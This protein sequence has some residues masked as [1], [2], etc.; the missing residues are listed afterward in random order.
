[1]FG[2]RESVKVAERTPLDYGLAM[3]PGNQQ[4]ESLFQ[5]GV[6]ALRQGRAR[7]A[8]LRF[9]QLTAAGSANGLTWLVLAMAR[10]AEGDAAGEEA[11]LNRVLELE[12]RSVSGNVMKGDC[13]A[14]CGDELG[15]I[16]F[17][18]AAVRLAEGVDLPAEA[19][20]EVGRAEQALADLNNR[21][22]ARRE[23]L[24][25]GRGVS[26]ETWS[27]RF[28][29][30]LELAAG[31]RKLYPQQ[32][33]IFYY[34]ELPQ[35]QF[36]DP[37]EFSWVPAIEAATA[38]IRDELVELLKDGT[39]DFRA[40]INNDAAAL[41]QD[42]TKSLVDN[43]D[44]SALFLCENG[45]DVARVIDHCPRTWETIQEAPQPRVPG[46]GPTAMFS[47]LKAGARIAPHT[48]MFNTRLV[49]HLPLIVPPGCNFRVGNEVR[50][51]EEGKLM[52]FDDTIEHEAWND[53]SEDRVVLIFDIWRPEL[54]EQEKRELTALFSA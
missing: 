32:P 51:W 18:K 30:S 24:L 3:E 1:M 2:A 6:E 17:Y 37:G 15:A 36:Y 11:A 27:N 33:T 42:A 52:I 22:H 26:P 50:A 31:R 21:A 5:D 10:R 41:R 8:R 46:W 48:G 14:N 53:S 4:A 45:A 16:Y 12:P 7:E 13:R 44:W 49:C 47:L 28:R 43:K 20:A 34:P 39:D 54:T 40:Y 35:V 23:A 9:E 25:T 38:A 29:H 19:T